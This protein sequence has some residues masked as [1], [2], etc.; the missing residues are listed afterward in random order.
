MVWVFHERITQEDL[1]LALA[2]TICAEAESRWHSP[3]GD[4]AR[5][6]LEDMVIFMLAALG[7]GLQGEEEPLIF[8]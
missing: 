8:L 7:A 5:E 2:M 4:N 6:E 3:V 1:I